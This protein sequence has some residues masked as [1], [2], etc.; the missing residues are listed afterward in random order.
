[1]TTKESL[2]DI[3]PIKWDKSIITVA[4]IANG[5]SLDRLQEICNAERDGRLAVLPYKVGDVVYVVGTCK[6]VNYWRDDDY[7]TGTGAI[8][9]P[10]ENDCE[11]DECS[12]T[13]KKIFKTTLKGVWHDEEKTEIFLI[14]LK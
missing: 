4:D 14:I 11:Y 10:Y 9:C 3:E 5:I 6:D 13:N 12:D 7:F 1:M 2:K 8:E